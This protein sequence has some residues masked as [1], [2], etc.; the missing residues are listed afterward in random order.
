MG[1][2]IKNGTIVTAGARVTGD[3]Y[4]DGGKIAAIGLNLEKRQAADQMIDAS[5]QYVLSRRRSTRTSTWSCPSWA[6]SRSDDFETGTAAAWPA[7]PPPSSTSSS[8]AGATRCSTA[9]HEWREKSHERGRRLHLPHGHHRLDRPDGRGDAGR[10]PGEGDH[11][12][13]GL[14]GLQGRHHGRRRR[15]LSGH[16]GGGRARRPRHGARR[17]RRRGLPPAEGT[18]GG[19][20]AGPGVPP[21]QPPVQ[22]RGRGH[23]AGPDDG[24]AA[25]RHR[26]HR[27]HDLPRGGG[28]A[29]PRQGGGPALLRRDLPAV[30]AA[31]RLGLREA[32][33]RG[34]PPT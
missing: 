8:R 10:R 29:G 6:P 5:G 23:R 15:A 17:E 28:G 18:G 31:R 16:A 13:Q 32:G 34:R 14:H 3:V 12:L 25:R 21:G 11:L 30:S 1:L 24:P 26:L 33:L 4:C 22:R 27:A 20:P 9:S 19:R 2:L 7:A